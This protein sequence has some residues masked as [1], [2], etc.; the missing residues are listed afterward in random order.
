MCIRTRRAAAASRIGAILIGPDPDHRHYGVFRLSCGH[1][2]RRQYYRIERAAEGDCAA[3]CETCREERYD[4]IARDH[5]WR[6]VGPAASG[7]TGY[8]SYRHSCGHLQDV[9]NG[10]MR[11]G[12]VDCAACGESWTSKP[13]Q[14]YLFRVDL[15][16]EQVLKLGYSSNPARR[17]R[18]QLGITRD[19]PSRILRTVPVPTGHDAVC[20]EKKAHTYMRRYNP[21][22]IVPKSV[23]GDAINT[24]SEIYHIS[25]EPIL[26]HL[27][28]R[29]EAGL[30]ISSP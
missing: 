11:W 7:R 9:S 25:A 30:P 18:Q 17:L 21:E 6:L 5:D 24:R 1:I 19:T 16:P 29:I 15:D 13:S 4:A 27:L 22:L 20:Q 10:N 8:R 14:L 3:G 26:R 23:Y 2:V 12:D 28:D